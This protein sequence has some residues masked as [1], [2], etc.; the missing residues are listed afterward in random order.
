MACRPGGSNGGKSNLDASGTY[1]YLT[2]TA[3][4]AMGVISKRRSDESFARALPPLDTA[5]ATHLDRSVI[6]STVLHLTIFD[7]SCYQVNSL[8]SG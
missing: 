2:Y 7:I 3:E 4:P 6:F 8:L 1:G 5:E